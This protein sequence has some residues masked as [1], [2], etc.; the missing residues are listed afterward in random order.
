[1]VPITRSQ[2]TY[3]CNQVAHKYIRL[4][5]VQILRVL[6]KVSQTNFTA[7]AFPRLHITRIDATIID[8]KNVNTLVPKKVPFMSITL[9]KVHNILNLAIN[10]KWKPPKHG[11]VGQRKLNEKKIMINH[12]IPSQG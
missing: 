6:G 11:K 5:K 3:S 7:D 4:N 2:V 9:P 10:F 8:V 12:T 1:M